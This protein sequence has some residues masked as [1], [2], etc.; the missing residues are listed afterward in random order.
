M[1]YLSYW[2]INIPKDKKIIVT[3]WTNKK[4]IL[5]GKYLQSKGY[6]VIGVLKGGI[7]RWRDEKLPVEHV[8]EPLKHISLTPCLD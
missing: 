8:D 4:A 1:V 3:D 7:V 6:D 2:H 5:A